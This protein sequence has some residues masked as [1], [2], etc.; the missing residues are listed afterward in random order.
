MIKLGLILVVIAL[1]FGAIM[2]CD[3]PPGS[4]AMPGDKFQSI[5]AAK[6][7]KGLNAKTCPVSGKSIKPGQGVEA[8]LSNGKKVM[9]CCPDCK[10]TIEKNLKKI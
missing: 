10:E 1:T 2:D 3:G 9:M 8:F 4:M 6:L 5:D 7:G